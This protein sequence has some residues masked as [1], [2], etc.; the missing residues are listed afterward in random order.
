MKIKEKQRMTADNIL[1]ILKEH[2][3]DLRKYS[4]KKIGLLGSC[5]RGEQKRQSD[6]DLLVEFDTSSFGKNFEGYFD[7]YMN[8]SSL[9]EKIF[10]K[11]VDLLTSDMISPY[12]RPYVLK[13]VRYL[14]GV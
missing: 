12:I 8:L 6:I 5:V 1:G 7:T 9:L 10:H 13:E 3:D 14:E 11:K 4:V 2:A